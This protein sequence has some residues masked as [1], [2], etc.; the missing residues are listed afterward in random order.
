[1]SDLL[2]FTLFILAG[3]LAG[4]I[5]VMAGGGSALT[6]PMLVLMGYDPTVANGSN[7]IAILVEAV[8]G[9]AAFRR[10]QY[11]DFGM[12]WKLGLMTLPGAILGAIYAVRVDD[13]L[14]MKLLGLVMILVILSLVFPKARVMEH[15]RTHRW[16]GWLRW[17]AMFLIGLYG[18]FIQAGVGFMIMA[19]LTHL[20]QMDLVRVNMHKVF[21]TLL[22]TLPAVILFIWTGNIN[23]FAAIGL[24]VGMSLGAWL[25][26]KAS[27]RK[28]ERLVRIT[29]MVALGMVAIKLLF[30]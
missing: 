29:L 10:H 16:A 9:V 24:S 14:F 15:A 28:G 8:V 21:I 13:A 17:P 3:G 22:F 5:N 18:G 25:A 30:F 2:S 1:M 19:G 6:V 27:I 11:S 23:W 20:Y 26:V 12:S 4:F 7:R